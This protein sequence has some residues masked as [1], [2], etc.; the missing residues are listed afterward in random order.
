MSYESAESMA[1]KNWEF[2]IGSTR[3]LLRQLFLYLRKKSVR[4]SEIFLTAVLSRGVGFS[5]F[6]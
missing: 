3:V 5:A 6:W 2:R 1:V 4:V